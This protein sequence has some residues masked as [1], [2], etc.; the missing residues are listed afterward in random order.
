MGFSGDYHKRI[1]DRSFNYGD[2]WCIE[3]VNYAFRNRIFTCYW[4][5]IIASGDVSKSYVAASVGALGTLI[6]LF[7]LPSTKPEVGEPEHPIKVL[8]GGFQF[9]FSNRIVGSVILIGTLAAV[10]GVV[11]IFFPALASHPFGG[12]AIQV[13]LMFSAIS[14]GR[15]YDWCIDE[16]LG[17]R[18]TASWSCYVILRCSDFWG[19]I[20]SG[21]HFFNLFSIVT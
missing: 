6:P 4:G 5:V 7:R 18:D 14:L 2:C 12:G 19:V 1:G 3:Y 16:W 9:L 21:S 17:A 15:G 13:G 10:A 8:M 20:Y 11:R